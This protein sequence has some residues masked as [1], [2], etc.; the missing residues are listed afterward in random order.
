MPWVLIA[1]YLEVSNK[2]YEA[3]QI[4]ISIQIINAHE[5]PMRQRLISLN[6]EKESSQTETPWDLT[7]FARRSPKKP[8][9]PR[10]VLLLHVH[11]GLGLEKQLDHLRVAI[12]RRTVQR[13]P[14]SVRSPSC[15]RSSGNPDVPSHKMTP[16]AWHEVVRVDVCVSRPFS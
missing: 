3:I 6:V 7:K 13:G 10:A 9:R 16:K 8:Q 5:Q 4:N 12:F 15:G 14:A 11:R 1:L 2:I